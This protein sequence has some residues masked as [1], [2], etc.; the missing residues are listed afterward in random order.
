[1]I[2]EFA[3]V[4]IGTGE[5]LADLVAGVIELVDSSGLDYQL[6][7]MGT[8]VEGEWDEVFGLIK[9]CHLH[10]RRKAGRV[11]TRV[12]VDDRDKAAGRIKGKV[13]DVEARLGRSLKT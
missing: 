7:A 10:M 12:T 9:A 11:E 1:M 5:E 13:A 8:I 2:V 4:P 6:T 3:V